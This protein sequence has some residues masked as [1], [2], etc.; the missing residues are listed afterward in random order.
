MPARTQADKR[1]VDS[2]SL[3]DTL[4]LPSAL[5]SPEFQ[6]LCGSADPE[7]ALLMMAR[8]MPQRAASK[9]EW[10]EFDAWIDRHYYNQPLAE[11]LQRYPVDTIDTCMGGV[12][13]GIVTPKAGIPA[14]NKRR[15]LINLHSGA[16]LVSR[17]LTTGTL[18]SV[19][20]AAIGGMEVVTL[21]YRQAPY[22]SYPA[23]SED[24]EAVY[25]EL[26]REYR[27]E[28]VGIF[29]CS[30]GGIL[31]AQAVARLKSKR[32]PL[33]GAIGIFSMAPPPPY[34]RTPPW[35]A[36]WGD[37]RLWFA[38][39]PRTVPT[40]IDRMLWEAAFWY[41]ESA[42]LSDTNAYPGTSDE[43][44]S[45]FPPTLFLTGTRDFAASTV[46]AAH[47]RFLRL[48]VKAS[49]YIME[50]AP[51]A[52]HVNAVGTQEA[53]DAQMQVASWFDQHLAH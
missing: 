41:M 1:F 24:V 51:H 28:S 52:A 48:G 44:L 2:E 42:D 20:V 5:C 9:A 39:T 16:F 7:E 18:E 49:L 15:V 53:H 17:G 50:G 26:L 45:Q 13:V 14:K 11:A 36:A 40:P 4:S 32:M 12:R 25:Q 22:F 21:D 33:P 37:S 23:A 34:G 8:R 43:V 38:G 19:P 27:P 6:R 3:R 31:A 35:G 29:G 30:A 47:A 10:D 46:T